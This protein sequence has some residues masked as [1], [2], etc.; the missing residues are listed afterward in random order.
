M[1]VDEIFD[2]KIIQQICPTKPRIFVPR[3]TIIRQSITT[4]SLSIFFSLS[5]FPFLFF[6]YSFLPFF[7]SS[8]SSFSRR[9]LTLLL[10]VN[11]TILE[12]KKRG[13]TSSRVAAKTNGAPFNLLTGKRDSGVNAAELIPRNCFRPCWLLIWLN[14]RLIPRSNKLRGLPPPRVV[15]PRFPTVF[16]PLVSFVPRKWIPDIK[17]YNANNVIA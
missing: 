12:T 4:P 10:I 2:D 16:L 9:S 8:V 7:P 6:L 13:R 11:E 14:S 3:S 15:N 5:S 17:I 1:P